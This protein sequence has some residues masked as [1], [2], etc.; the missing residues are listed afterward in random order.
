MPQ[1]LVRNLLHLVYST[2]NRTPWIPAEVR[3]RL[4]AYQAGIF[5]EWDSPAIIIGGVDDRVHALFSLSKN[6]ALIKIVEE[7]KKGSSKWMKTETGNVDFY[8]QNGYATFSVSRSNEDRVNLYIQK[9][10]EHHRT[11][12]FQDELRELLKRHR[13]EFDERYVWD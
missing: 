1:S 7:V 4:F 13:V 3:P 12:S 11:L 9:Q 6:H 8:W 5:K 2:K 10:E